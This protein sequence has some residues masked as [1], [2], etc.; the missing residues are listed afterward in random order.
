MLVGQLAEPKR[1][2]RPER[3]LSTLVQSTPY[4][5]LVGHAN[6]ALGNSVNVLLRLAFGF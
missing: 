4:L 1:N 2:K 3:P 6:K 5:L